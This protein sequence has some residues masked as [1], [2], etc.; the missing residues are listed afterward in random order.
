MRDTGIDK[1]LIRKFDDSKPY[2]GLGEGFFGFRKMFRTYLDK[3]EVPFYDKCCP[4]VTESG[5]FPTRFNTN[6][7]SLE[8]FNGT[9][10]VSVDDAGNLTATSTAFAGGGQGSAT[11]LAAGTTNVTTVATAGDSVKLPTA[12]SGISVTVKNNGATNLAVFPFTGD[13]IDGGS[14]NAS[15][16]IVPGAQRTFLAMNTT[17]WESN[18]EVVDTSYIALQDGTVGGLSLRLG[19]DG[20]NGFYGVSDTVIG[21]AVEGAQVATWTATGLTIDN[22]TERTADAG[23]TLSK[24]VVQ[25]YTTFAVPITATVLAANFKKGYFT[26][27]SAA[28]VSLT[29]D[30]ATAIATAIGAVAGTVFDFYV[31]NSAG[32]N[33]VTVVLG[34]GIVAATP[35]ITGGGTLTV[36]TANGVGIFRLVFTSATAARIYRIG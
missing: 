32:A 9:S 25:K 35:V 4:A 34:A 22:I 15:V 26:S 24:A 33:T 21:V 14:V 17:N 20:N 29:T 6:S 36:S 23:I 11:Q 30:T 5:I 1:G 13:S 27:T 28:A 31:D 7:G 18:S 16:T 19:A 2:K 3:L 12:A 8:R 10:W